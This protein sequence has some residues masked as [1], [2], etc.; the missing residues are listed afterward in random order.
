MADIIELDEYTPGVFQIEEDTVWLGGEAGPANNQGKAL[1]NRTKWLKAQLEAL[2]DGKQPLDADLTAIAALV[3]AA[4]KM[5]YA[6]GAG[7]WALA[8]LSAFARTLL[9]DAD[10]ATA[11]ATLG[12]ASPADVAAAIAALVDA[13]PATLDTLNELAAALGDDANFAATMATALALKAPLASPAFSGVPTV[14]T[15]APGTNTTQAAST[16]FV[17]AAVGAV[18]GM[19]TGMVFTVP[20]NAAPA[21]SIK[22]NGALL[23]RATYAALWAYAQASGNLAASDGAWVAGQFSP[24]DGATTF[25]IPDGRGEFLRGWDDGRGIDAG[26]TIGSAQADNFKAHS[27]GSYGFSQQVTGVNGGSSYWMGTSVLLTDGGGG[28]ETRPRNLALLSCIKY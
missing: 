15:A 4:D 5:P 22:L 13:S 19:P 10:A 11:R 17:A 24:G 27:H 3:S 26:R 18:V 20:G 7:A 23:S 1:A 25:R 9:D 16:A 2:A 6:T 8:T 14:P 12:A 28:T 21:G